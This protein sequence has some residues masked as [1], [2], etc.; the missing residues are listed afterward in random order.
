ML[1][2]KENFGL[3]RDDGFARVSSSSGPVLDRIR[4]DI[5][6]ILKNEGL[7]IIFKTNL[8]KR[9][10]LDVTLNLLP[11][12]IFIFGKVNNKPLYLN[13]KSYYLCT[14]IKELLKMINK[15]LP[16]LSCNQEEFDKV[17]GSSFRKQL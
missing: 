16:Y 9:D 11:G 2:G 1:L 12:N 14:T 3:F 4:K 15:R 10:F 6:A 5:I 7:S 17:R 8:V 13:A